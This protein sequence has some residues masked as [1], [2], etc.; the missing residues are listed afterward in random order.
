MTRPNTSEK[1]AVTIQC[2]PLM[3]LIDPVW[4][5]TV[6][7]LR[8]EGTELIV[9]D[10]ERK[11]A[12]TTYGIPIL[13]PTPNRVR[14]NAYIFDGRTIEA[15]MHGF[16]R[17]QEFSV[18]A[19]KPDAVSA[20]VEFDGSNPLFP[21]VGTFEVDITV[22]EQSIRWSFSVTNAGQA[23][24]A[25]GLALHPFFRKTERMHLRANVGHLMEDIDKYPTGVLLPLESSAF[26]FSHPR[27]VSP[28][29]ID[30]VFVTDGPIEAEISSATHTIAISGSDAFTHAVVYTGESLPFICV[31]PQ[32]CA[33]DAHNL[34]SRG[35]G[36]EAGLIIVE[37]GS[38]HHSWVRFEITKNAT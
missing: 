8:H 12:G 28:L 19:V 38:R 7:S 14:D 11:M 4:G 16:I 32:S 10:R 2:G 9:C 5:M 30:A 35:Y 22:D 26:D 21:Y 34:S 29:D 13:F 27:A 20:L 17:H 25:I 37:P 1:A 31:E 18:T 6:E 24:F 36:E 15:V 3:A 33:T 23:R